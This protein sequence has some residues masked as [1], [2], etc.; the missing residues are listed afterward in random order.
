MLL[1]LHYGYQLAFYYEDPKHSPYDYQDDDQIRA[2]AQV[3]NR[4]I[5]EFEAAP[6]KICF[7]TIR[8]AGH[9]LNFAAA[10]EEYARIVGSFIRETM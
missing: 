1:L 10:P 2:C 5:A 4:A 3:W 8:G 6:E 7:H 9:A